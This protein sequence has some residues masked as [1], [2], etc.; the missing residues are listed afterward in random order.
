MCPRTARKGKCG[1]ILYI[2]TYPKVQLHK[3]YTPV[4]GETFSALALSS[5]RITFAPVV[6]DT[7]LSTVWSKPSL[8]TSLRTDCTL[9]RNKKKKKKNTE[10]SGREIPNKCWCISVKNWNETLR[11]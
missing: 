5:F 10:E 3:L 1:Q 2:F 4:T 9:Q 6:A 8:W 7:L 11:K